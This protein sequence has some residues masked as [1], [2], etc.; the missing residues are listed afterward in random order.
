MSVLDR[1]PA[2]LPT[3]DKLLH[4]AL[5]CFSQKGYYQTTT[6]EIVSKSGL[7]K[8]TLYRHFKNKH[9][10][11]VSLVRWMMQGIGEEMDHAALREQHALEQ[12]RQIVW[13][14]VEEME[15]MLPF[16]RLTLDYWAHTIDDEQVREIF[17]TALSDFQERL[18]PVIEAGIEAGEIRPVNASE[19]ALGLFAMLD[20]LGLY[21]ALLEDEI[22]LKP[23][24]T[25]T[26]DIYLA[27]LRQNNVSA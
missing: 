26:L 18:A 6:D 2:E 22:V 20:A 8:G 25:T 16:F 5:A 15:Q 27:G 23:V 3:R 13:M 24:I 17:S 4:A 19:A 1:S 7:G 10:L 11:F 21:K 12:L 9:D 14:V